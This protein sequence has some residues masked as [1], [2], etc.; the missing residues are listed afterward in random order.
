MRHIFFFTLY[1][2]C[3]VSLTPLGIQA[4]LNSAASSLTALERIPLIQGFGHLIASVGGQDVSE[5]GQSDPS[6]P[7]VLHTCPLPPAPIFIHLNS[8]YAFSDLQRP[9]MRV[10]AAAGRSTSRKKPSG[11]AR[12]GAGSRWP[13]MASIASVYSCSLALSLAGQIVFPLLL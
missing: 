11:D 2:I 10:H 7:R 13:A 12:L 8:I 5:L 3:Q 6:H 9:L 4:P 1:V